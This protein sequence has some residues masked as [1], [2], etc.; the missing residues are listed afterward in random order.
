MRY[1]FY[2]MCFFSNVRVHADVIFLDLNNADE[3]YKACKAGIK[4]NNQDKGKQ[5]PDGIVR[6][7]GENGEGDDDIGRTKTYYKL[8]QA[9]IKMLEKGRTIDSIVI[10]GDDGT[11]HFFGTN[12]DFHHHELRAILEEFPQVGK[13]LQSSALWGCYGPTLHGAEQF[14]INR[15]PNMKFSMGFT[16]QGPA[17]D[18]PVNHSLLKQFC[19]KREEAVKLT[20]KDQLCDFY[21]KLQK[22]VPTSLGICNRGN[23]ASS[24]YKDAN[25]EVCF[26]EQEIRDR[27]REFTLDEKLNQTYEDYLTGRKTPEKEVP[28]QVTPMRNYYNKLNLWRHCQEQFKKDRNKRMPFGPE[29][30]ALVKY[31]NLVNTFNRLNAKELAS[32]DQA[33]ASANLGQFA[34]SDALRDPNIDR[35]KVNALIRGAVKATKNSPRHATLHRMAKCLRM[36]YERLDYRCHQFKNIDED[37]GGEPSSCLMTYDRAKVE[38]DDDDC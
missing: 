33:M 24:E 13:T 29:V 9:V 6:V 38:E 3:E 12:G 11:G 16:G 34:I 17:K 22:L 37:I 21:H 15:M 36:T 28:G 2:L 4:Q 23:F 5:Q 1:L 31:R 26:T 25:G 14:W 8:R 10:S 19:Q 20:T 32:Y 30:I 35:G 18:R 7:R 27:C